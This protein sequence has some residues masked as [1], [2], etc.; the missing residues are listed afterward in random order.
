MRI[1]LFANLLGDLPRRGGGGCGF[2]PIPVIADS[3]RLIGLN[4]D[5]LG[6]VDCGGSAS[7]P[8][9]PNTTGPSPSV[10]AGVSLGASLSND[11]DLGASSQPTVAGTIGVGWRTGVVPPSLPS[12]LSVDLDLGGVSAL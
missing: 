5:D 8:S 4:D 2:L 7:L 11:L 1:F 10:V 9:P 6:S 12:L 3:A